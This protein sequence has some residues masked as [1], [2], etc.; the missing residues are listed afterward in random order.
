MASGL[1]RNIPHGSGEKQPV[2]FSHAGFTLLGLQGLQGSFLLP[3]RIS[4]KSQ[5]RLDPFYQQVG[6]ESQSARPWLFTH[7]EIVCFHRFPIV[8]QQ[9]SSPCGPDAARAELSEAIWAEVSL[10]NLGSALSRLRGCGERHRSDTAG[11]HSLETKSVALEPAPGLWASVSCQ[12]LL[13]S[14]SSALAKVPLAASGP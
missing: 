5:D 13:S 6:L 8:H 3:R 7:E 12:A 10:G 4:R 9:I 2:L 14:C 1:T 11:L